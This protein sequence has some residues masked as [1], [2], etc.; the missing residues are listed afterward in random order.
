[1]AQL[2]ACLRF[3]TV[4]SLLLT[5]VHALL[6]VLLE[7]AFHLGSEHGRSLNFWPI[8]E[9]EK[10]VFLEFAFFLALLTF[11]ML[12]LAGR[13]TF[14]L[15]NDLKISFAFEHRWTI[16][17]LLL[18]EALLAPEGQTHLGHVIFFA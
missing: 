2:T 6:I 4:M 3:V 9:T 17:H 15:I 11:W 5:K 16:L 18:S 7:L 8:V 10:H 13:W 12:L 14:I 1:M